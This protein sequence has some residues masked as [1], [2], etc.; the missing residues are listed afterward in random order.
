MMKKSVKN[1]VVG[2][3]IRTSAGMVGTVERVHVGGSLSTV[4]LVHSDGM[5]TEWVTASLTDVW[6]N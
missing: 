5:R 2:D 1:V 6:V 3:V 4:S